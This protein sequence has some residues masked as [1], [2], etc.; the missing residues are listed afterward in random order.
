MSIYLELKPPKYRNP[1]LEKK[2]DENKH[3]S[4]VDLSRASLTDDDIDLVAYYLLRNNKVNKCVYLFSLV[5]K[6]G[7]QN[8]EWLYVNC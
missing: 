2:I 4:S 5:K 6:R 1:K 3:E 8:C 7:E